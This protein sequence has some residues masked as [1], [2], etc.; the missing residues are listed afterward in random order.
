[1]RTMKNKSLL[2]GLIFLLTAAVGHLFGQSTPGTTFYGVEA[3]PVCWTTAGGVDS[4]IY[5][6]A[7]SP[8]GATKPTQLF[9]YVPIVGTAKVQAVTVSGGTI[10]PGYCSTASDDSITSQLDIIID[11]LGSGTD[12]CQVDN[13]WRV[14]SI[15]SNTTYATNTYNSIAIESVSGTVTVSVDGGSAVT[16]AAGTVLTVRADACRYVQSPV[17]VNVSGGSAIIS[18]YY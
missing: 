5:Q 11:L 9:F 3:Q 6:V 16:L 15:T 17:T 8:A 7:L 1:M 4:T 2:F 13:E 10:R 12:T 14:E 18:R